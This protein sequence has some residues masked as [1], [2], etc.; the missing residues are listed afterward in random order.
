MLALYSLLRIDCALPWSNVFLI[1]CRHHPSFTT[2]TLTS[3][4]WMG[5]STWNRFFCGVVILMINS[6]IIGLFDLSLSI[7]L[8]NLSYI[9]SKLRLGVRWY[10]IWIQ[11]SH[12]HNFWLKSLFLF[13]DRHILKSI[14]RSL[15]M[16]VLLLRN[17]VSIWFWLIGLCHLCIAFVVS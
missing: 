14:S 16:R 4:L 1:R 3:S 10:N 7:Q 6:L 9:I 12:V 2:L 5:H 15:L 11:T 17:E 13:I 8:S